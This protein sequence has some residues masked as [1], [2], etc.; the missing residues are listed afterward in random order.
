MANQANPMVITLDHF[1][2]M[3]ENFKQHYFLS[4]CNSNFGG[5]D[6]QIPWMSFSLVVENFIKST[7]IKPDTV[8]LRFV[9][10]Y[11]SMKNELYLRLQICTMVP[12]AGKPNAFNLDTKN[13]AWYTIANGSIA[14]TGVIDPYD[15]NYLNNFYYCDA[16]ICSPDSLV[17]LASDTGAEKFVRNLVFPWTE[18]IQKLHIDN[19]SPTN[20]TICFAAGS[21]D[22]SSPVLDHPHALVIYLR[23]Y[24]STPLLDNKEYPLEF[25]MKAG[26]MGTLC[27]TFCGV[28]VLPTV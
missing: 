24:D 4:K 2:T 9:L 21:H 13:C 3:R 14:P 5:Q 6:I 12:I 18:E 23:K 20:A 26:D 19:G 17:N 10:C 11:D 22:K 16:N 15:Q 25:Q 7:Q 27:P 1:N 28:Y 8:A